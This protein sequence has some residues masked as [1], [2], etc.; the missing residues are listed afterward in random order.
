M[1]H[2]IVSTRPWITGT[3]IKYNETPSAE[4]IRP[5]S[6]PDSRRDSY[7]P[8]VDLPRSPRY[9]TP[10]GWSPSTTVQVLTRRA[11]TI[12]LKARLPTSRCWQ[13]RVFT[14]LP[15]T[16]ENPACTKRP[17]NTD[18]GRDD[19]SL[20]RHTEISRPHENTADITRHE[21]PILRHESPPAR[22]RWLPAM[23]TRTR[24]SHDIIARQLHPMQ[25]PNGVE[26][27]NR[28]RFWSG[29]PV[30]RRKGSRMGRFQ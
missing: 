19:A 29:M 11:T 28:L 27:S 16:T 3:R 7:R 18:A 4:P 21:T 12:R 5:A 9:P 20:P 10:L 15:R 17:M 30:G 25:Q 1:N 13:S 24:Q 8:S 23:A 2:P 22:R 6:P 26:D 14:K